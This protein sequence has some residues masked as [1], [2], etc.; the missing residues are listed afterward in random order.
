[1]PGLVVHAAALLLALASGV[2]GQGQG[3]LSEEEVEEILNAHNYYRQIVDP[4]ATNM[5]KMVGDL[6]MTLML[7]SQDGV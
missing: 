4:V 7:F 5:L 3:G 1:M 6:F 2:L